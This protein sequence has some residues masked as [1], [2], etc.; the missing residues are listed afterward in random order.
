MCYT[1]DKA[2]SVGTRLLYTEM[3][4]LRYG[5]RLTYAMKRVHPRT[6]QLALGF[7]LVLLLVAAAVWSLQN[8]PQASPD[9]IQAAD[10]G[11][12]QLVA[13]GQQLYSTRCAGCHGTN[14]QGQ[15]NWQQPQAGGMLAAPPL[16]ASGPSVQRT[17]QQLFAII[18]EGGQAF[19][20][21][22]QVSGMPP[23]GGSLSDAQIWA[24]VSYMKSTWPPQ[25]QTVQ[26]ES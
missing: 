13:L 22:D 4:R 18:A 3:V 9:T 20:Q 26:P 23:F 11:D 12:Q 17:D 2:R 7:V 6:R 16:D 24:L 5:S 21:P 14:L 25:T 1:S 10:P 19:V 15:P 8:R